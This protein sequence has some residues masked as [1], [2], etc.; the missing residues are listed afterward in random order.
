[1]QRMKRNK[2]ESLL[3]YLEKQRA[4]KLA[5]MGSYLRYLREEQSLSLDEVATKTKVQARLLSA[6]EEGNLDPLPEPVYIQG[7]IKRYADAVGLD[8]A[9]FA[10]VFPTGG[11]FQP[12]GASWQKLPA[13][14]LK[15]IHL[16]LLYIFLV[17]CAV[18]GLSQIVK[19]SAIQASAEKMDK[20]TASAPPAKP[21]K[22]KSENLALVSSTSTKNIIRADKPVRVSVTL[23]EQSWI[24]VVSDGKKEFEG[25]LPEGTQRTWVAKQELIIRAGN[26]GGVL[27]TFNERQTEPL[28][29]SS[30][31]QTKSFK[32]SPGG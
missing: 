30:T 19:N 32:A 22:P 8:G 23:K 9:E 27:V 31:P 20:P 24:R 15:P 26:A 10:S 1:M 18:S 28:G 6:I 16:Y 21:E 11:S 17:I 13:A 12:I 29:S 7:F 25:T 4:E 2:K 5:E 3:P 14:Q